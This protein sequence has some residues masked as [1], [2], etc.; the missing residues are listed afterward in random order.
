MLGAVRVPL[1]ATLSHKPRPGPQDTRCAQAPLAKGNNKALLLQHQSCVLC[2]TPPPHERSVAAACSAR[3]V[4]A[5]RVAHREGHGARAAIPPRGRE[6][7]RVRKALHWARNRARGNGVAHAELAHR[8]AAAPRTPPR[9]HL[10]VVERAHTRLRLS[11]SHAP[12]ACSPAPSCTPRRTPPPRSS[13]PPA[14]SHARAPTCAPRRAT[15]ATRRRL[16]SPTPPC[17]TCMRARVSGRSPS[18]HPSIH[19][20][21]AARTRSCA[22]PPR[23]PRVPPWA[24]LVRRRPRAGPNHRTPMCAAGPPRPR[25]RRA[26]RRTQLQPPGGRMHTRELSRMR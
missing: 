2:A 7:D 19:P 13:C 10:H 20:R 24:P 14:R 8:E 9:V 18:I 6:R 17:H 3:L 5:R 23:T 4:L 21:A 11:P 1:C 12:R 15:R 25:P 26:C 22:R 16:R